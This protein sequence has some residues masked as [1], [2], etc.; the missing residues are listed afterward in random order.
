VSV[1]DVAEGTLGGLAGCHD[2]GT[3]RAGETRDYRFSARWP[4]SGDDNPYGGSSASA[5]LHWELGGECV[6]GSPAEPSRLT[7]SH[8]HVALVRGR[9]RLRVR[10]AGGACAGAIYLRPRAGL[11]RRAATSRGMRAR[12]AVSGGQR[13]TLYVPLPA[14]SRAALRKRHRA[15]ALAVVEPE[16]GKRVTRLVTLIRHAPRNANTPASRR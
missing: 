8:R 6:P 9:A 10:C 7:L 15:V 14:A 16:G 11:R 3:L 12:F 5:D 1:S 2:L 4:A 13:A